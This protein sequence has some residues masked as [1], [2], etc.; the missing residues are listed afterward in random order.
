MIRLANKDDIK[1]INS[2]GLLV[3]SN[4]TK[5]YNIESYLNSNLYIILVNEVK[6]LVNAFLLVLNN[7]DCYEI[8]MIVVSKEVRHQGIGTAL[9]NHFLENYRIKDKEILLEVAINNNYAIDFYKKVG[10][11]IIN[12]RKKYYNGIDALV[13]KKVN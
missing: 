2:L 10:F 11:N 7:V 9:L 6:G 8:E 3:N 5:T 4:F 12:V 13:M 1:I